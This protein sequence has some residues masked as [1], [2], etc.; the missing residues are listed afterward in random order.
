MYNWTFYYYR[1]TIS[2]RLWS[3]NLLMKVWQL[4]PSKTL[5]SSIINM[6]TFFPTTSHLVSIEWENVGSGR[7]FL[8]HNTYTKM[9]VLTLMCYAL[10]LTTFWWVKT[11]HIN[12][13]LVDECEFSQ[14]NT[15]SMTHKAHLLLKRIFYDKP[16]VIHTSTRYI[17][18]W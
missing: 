15:L 8:F 13:E 9:D 3:S 1:V 7:F 18:S 6:L 11:Q 4:R 10:E 5:W 2:S 17:E 12:Q 16:S 14:N